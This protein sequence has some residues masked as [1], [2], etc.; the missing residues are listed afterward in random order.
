[1][2]SCLKYDD[3]I[4]INTYPS[5]YYKAFTLLLMMY[6]SNITRAM[7]IKWK[8]NIYTS[9]IYKTYYKVGKSK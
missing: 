5:F 1:M 3:F 7:Y 8:Q 6:T 9:F 4:Y 2:L